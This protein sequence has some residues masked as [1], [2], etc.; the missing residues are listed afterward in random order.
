MFTFRCPWGRPLRIGPIVAIIAFA[1]S[2]PLTPAQQ[3]EEVAAEACRTDWKKCKDNGAIIH[4]SAGIH[5]RTECKFAADKLAK[6]GTPE[7]PGFPA[8]SFNTF[9]SGKSALITGHMLLVEND[10]K[11][12]N[13]FG[14]M[15]HVKV[16]C[17]YNFNDETAIVNI[18]QQ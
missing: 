13:I 11:F 8:Y 15:A 2:P 6:Y 14:A 4:A 9:N 5:A 10:A 12:K 1:S 3:Q 16:T 18:E 17:E 7:W